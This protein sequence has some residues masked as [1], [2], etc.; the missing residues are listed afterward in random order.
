M[1]DFHCHLDLYD[2]PKEVIRSS[3]QEGIYILSVTTTPRAFPGT[4]RMA[5][6]A[7]RIRTALGLHPQLASERYTELK[8]FDLM[9]PETDY[10]GEIGLDGSREF[11]SSLDIQ[12]TVFRHILSNVSACVSDLGLC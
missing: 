9:L 8:L 3:E 6:R 1:M 12:R 10:V 2:K 4:K 7:P 5:A 11:K